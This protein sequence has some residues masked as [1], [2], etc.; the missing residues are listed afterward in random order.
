[1]PTAGEVESF[2]KG[3][4]EKINVF[5]IAFRPRNKNLDALAELDI[6]PVERIEYLMNLRAE[7]YCSG[8]NKD[9]Y[10]PANP[11]YY[12]F[13]VKVKGVEVYI[14]ISQGLSNKRVDCMSFHPAEFTIKYPLKNK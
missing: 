3:L 7:D 11:D 2:I 5:D 14:K 9:T 10:D 4:I 13:G 12:E 6:S 1:M 8:P